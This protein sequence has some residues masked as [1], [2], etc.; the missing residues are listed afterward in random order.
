MTETITIE[1]DEYAL[2]KKK[3]KIADDIILQLKSSLYDLKAGRI[4]RVL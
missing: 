2:L 1:Q 4:R 3:E